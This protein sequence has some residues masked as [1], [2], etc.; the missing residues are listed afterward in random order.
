MTAEGDFGTRVKGD[1]SSEQKK[2]FTTNII[3]L[4]SNVAQAKEHSVLNDNVAEVDQGATHDSGDEEEEE[5]TTASSSEDDSEH[6]EEDQRESGVQNSEQ[7][8]ASLRRG[9]GRPKFI[10]TGQ[11]GRP[12]KQYHLLNYMDDTETPQ[13]AAEALSGHHSKDWHKSMQEEYDALIANKTW[14]LVEL[15]AGQK[16]IGSKWVFRIKR[17]AKGDIE[18]FKSRLVAKGCAQQLGVNYWETFSPVIR[19][20]TIRMLFAIAAE[21]QLYMHQIDI[22]NAYLNSELHEDVYMKQPE[23]FINKQ[24]PNKVLKLRKAIYGLKQS[25]RAWNNTLDE[26][27]KSIGFKR[28][29]NEPCLY[30]K[31]NKQQYSYIAVYVDDLIIMSPSKADI[32]EIK[33]KI[34]STFNMQDGGPIQY[35]L[36]LEVQRDGERGAIHLSQKK[37]IKSVLNTYGMQNCRAVATPLDPGFQ[38]GCQ[39]ENCSIVNTTEYQSLIGSLMYLAVLSRPDIMHAVSKLSQ[40]NTNPHIEHETAAKHIFRYLAGTS[41]ISIIYRKSD[42]PV[43][44]FADADWANDPKDRKSYSGYA[45][46]LGSSVFSWASTKQ[47]I[48]ALSSTEAEYVALSTAA[49]EA[50]YLSR[51]LKEIGWSST[52]PMTLYGDNISAQHIARNPIHHKRTKH[53]D[54]KYH[55]I[56]EKVESNEI[57]LEYVSTDKNVADVLT[58]SLSKQKHCNFI[59]MLGMK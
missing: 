37:Y 40:R 56:R 44:G 27:L 45:F 48:T 22:S 9:P 50:V 5:F 13:T 16:A 58:K 49:K 59:K 35:F 36:G 46:F 21:K 33:K 42:E 18:R 39:D 7:Q 23:N 51:L 38:V 10:R 31:Q 47:N 26:V 11:V 17:N 34:G 24:H 15:P 52:H 8:E 12:K 32:A 2:D 25:G 20:E 3:R 30:V 41:D 55:F 29:K 6:Q 53:I 43:K 57:K 19:Y 54:I 4:E 28:C 14:S 1:T